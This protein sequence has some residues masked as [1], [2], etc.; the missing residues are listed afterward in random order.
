MNMKRYIYTNNNNE[1]IIRRR[2]P[3]PNKNKQKQHKK[4]KPTHKPPRTINKTDT[5]I[6][7][8]NINI[9]KQKRI[10][11]RIRRIH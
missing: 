10:H 8:Y 6:Y 4:H 2:I 3:P 1:I 5:N 11:N 9:T 7:E